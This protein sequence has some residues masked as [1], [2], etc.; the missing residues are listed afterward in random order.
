[1]R[2]RIAK[3]TIALD[4]PGNS[5]SEHVQPKF[6]TTTKTPDIVQPK[7]VFFCAQLS[8]ILLILPFFT[9][10]NLLRSHATHAATA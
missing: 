10:F 3:R 5:L 9:V 8:K 1:M 7:V 4:P 2:D 6:I